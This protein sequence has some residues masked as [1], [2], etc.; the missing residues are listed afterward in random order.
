[1]VCKFTELHLVFTHNSI[2]EAVG[3]LLWCE[4]LR[5]QSGH[6]KTRCHSV[7]KETNALHHH[8]IVSIVTCMCYKSALTY[9]KTEYWLM[10]MMLRTWHP[11][12]YKVSHLVILLFID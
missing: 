7:T 10:V 6:I 5:T 2:S 9:E 8:D 3:S 11:C 4:V 1:M 12:Y